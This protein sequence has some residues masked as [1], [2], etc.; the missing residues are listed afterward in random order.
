[1]SS[2]P[3]RIQPKQTRD[4]RITF[5]ERRLIVEPGA[6]LHK[7]NA[8]EARNGVN[9]ALR[10]VEADQKI[11]VVMA[12]LSKGGKIVLTTGEECTAEDVIKH[13]S[14]WDHLFAARSIK[15]DQKWFKVIAHGIPT[16]AFP[17]TE[18]GMQELKNEIEEFNSQVKLVTRPHWLT[19]QETRA[20]KTHSSVIL[21]FETEEEAKVAIRRRLIVAATSVRTA[22]FVDARPDAQ[23]RRC[24][25]FGHGAATCKRQPKCQFCGESHETREHECTIC[26]AHKKGTACTHTT[27]KCANCGGAHK[28]NDKACEKIQAMKPVTNSGDTIMRDQ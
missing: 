12:T 15:R 27:Y 22:R 23:C 14:A 2:E 7:L 16:D 21:A 20:T 28:A 6:P 8:L 25:G 18:E 17:D 11:M 10:K 4:K 13:R 24:Q 9:A 5:R 26:P 3:V 19:K 1:V